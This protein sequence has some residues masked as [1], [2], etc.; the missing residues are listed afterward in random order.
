[1]TFPLSR[2]ITSL[3]RSAQND[4]QIIDKRMS[5]HHVQF[6]WQNNNAAI[7]RDLG[8]KNGTWL[9]SNRVTGDHP[10]HDGDRVRIGETILR[11]SLE[12]GPPRPVAGGA[13]AAAG[14]LIP[15]AGAPAAVRAAASAAA[16]AASPEESNSVKLVAEDWSATARHSHAIAAGAAPLEANRLAEAGQRYKRQ[17]AVGTPPTALG[18]GTRGHAVAPQPPAAEAENARVQLLIEVADAIRT[19]FDL[20]ELL[21]RL[22]ELIWSALDPDTGVILLVDEKTNRFYPKVVRDERSG[23]DAAEANGELTVSR[24]IV[25]K[26]SRERVSLLISDAERDE[27]FNASASVI[28]HRIRSAI[29]APIIHKER[30]LG[31][32]YVS[33]QKHMTFAQA[34]QELLTGIANQAAMAITN[35]QLHHQLVDQQKQERELEIAR[36]IQMNLLPKTKPDFKNFE[37]AGL[38]LPAKHVGGDY[39]DFVRAADGRWGIA[40]ADVSGKGVPAALLTTTARASMHVLAERGAVSP[41]EMVG[42]LNATICRDSLNNMFVTMVYGLVDDARR[43]VEFT[44]AGHAHPILFLP[45]GS[46][47]PLIEGGSFLGIDEE[48]EFDAGVVEMPPGSVLI[49]YTDGVTD[50]T[51]SDNQQFGHERFRAAARAHLTGSAEEIRDAIHQA[52]LDFRGGAPQFDDFTLIVLKCVQ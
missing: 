28:M 43:Q 12:G 26:A 38:S 5:R 50:A 17:Q 37:I 48:M 11:F 23:E 44:N 9:N 35:V 25:D 24:T 36:T 41:T 51:D 40:I 21:K 3:G 30:V 14:A 6:L 31:V 15:L 32:I 20:D 47:K 1:M 22:M 16:A 45:D 49:L 52:T 42:A 7:L 39:Y 8:S 18:P 13:P 46:E 27:R 2:E 29:C 33:S 4:I 34:D 10:L 19:I